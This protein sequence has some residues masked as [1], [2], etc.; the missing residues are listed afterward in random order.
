MSISLVQGL[1]IAL[2]AFV[3]GL[4][5]LLEFGLINRPLPA[6]AVTG[7]ILGD[8]ATGCIVGALAE[9]SFTGLVPMGGASVPDGTTAGVMSAVLAI[10]QNLAPTE[11]FA[12]SLPFGYL[13]QYLKVFK[14]TIFSFFNNVSDRIA[15][16]GNYKKLMHFHFLIM[17]ANGLMYAIV[18]F[19]CAYAAQNSIASIVSMFPEKLIA[20]LSIGG[21]LMP[22]IGFS[23]MLSIIYKT[24]YLPYVLIGFVCACFIDYGTILPVAVIGAAMALISYFS[25][26]DNKGMTEG[27]D[28]NGI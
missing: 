26:T 6:A 9:L 17:S 20:G 18:M 3:M 21:G 4:D 25:S 1:I 16:Q 14:N 13:V 28:I 19:L 24:K 15:L 10:T 2:W 23:M 7:I 8:P 27:D 5:D 11:A 22:A 12:L